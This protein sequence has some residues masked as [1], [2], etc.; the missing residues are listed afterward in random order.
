MDHHKPV[1]TRRRLVVCA[2]SV[3]LLLSF[4][5]TI[6]GQTLS[7]SGSPTALRVTTAVAGSAPT[8]AT[9]SATTYTATAKRPKDP[10]QIVGQL[11]SDMPAGTT[12][13]INLAPITGATSAGTVVL[14]TA[15]QMLVTDISNPNSRTA[16]ITYTFSATIAA[17]VIPP[18]TRI[19][20]FT[21]LAA[22]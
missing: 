10:Q 21:L 6:G 12:L 4:V 2:W 15:S 14:T 5:P 7:V 20:T 19:V 8:A 13:S 16:S 17:G 18:S 11:N 9:N 22:P 3:G 1:A